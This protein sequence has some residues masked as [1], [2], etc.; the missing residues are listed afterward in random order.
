YRLIKDALEL[1]VQQTEAY[2]TM[3]KEQVAYEK[4]KQQYDHLEA[5]WIENQAV[6]L[7]SHLHDGS[8]C[9]VCGSESHP[10]KA[11]ANETEVTKERLNE[12]KKKTDQ[13]HKT[14]MNASTMRSEEHTSE[15]QSRFD[16]VCR[17]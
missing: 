1:Y 13:A 10:H 7:A 6:V 14:F 15:L 12:A 9:P 2:Q 16:L 11:S 5:V 3:Q 8:S 17:L 4:E